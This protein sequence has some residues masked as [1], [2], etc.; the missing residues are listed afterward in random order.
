MRAFES[1]FH[2]MM[3]SDV[4]DLREIII[5]FGQDI[6]FPLKDQVYGVV[7]TSG[8]VNYLPKHVMIKQINDS[9]FVVIGAA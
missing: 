6:T 7:C 3:I 8:K 2:C 5:L 9:L 4:V 1:H